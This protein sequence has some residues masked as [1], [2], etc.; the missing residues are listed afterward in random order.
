MNEMQGLPDMTRNDPK[1]MEGVNNILDQY[2][3]TEEG[4]RGA[5][6]LSMGLNTIFDS[7]NETKGLPH[8]ERL[9]RAKDA[10]DAHFETAQLTHKQH[11]K[12]LHDDWEARGGHKTGEPRPVERFSPRY[13]KPQQIVPDPSNMFP[14]LESPILYVGKCEGCGKKLYD[15]ADSSGDPR[16]ALG[17]H[18]VG[19]IDAA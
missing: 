15:S 5:N 14:E 10:I 7:T 1:L 18:T 8:E 12:Q 6:A 19:T 11:V 2:P 13:T 17:E 16:G 4:E 3:D 9:Q